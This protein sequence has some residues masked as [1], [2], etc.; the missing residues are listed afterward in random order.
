MLSIAIDHVT[1]R[2]RLQPGGKRHQ[3]RLARV[4][5]DALHRV[6]E[7]ELERAGVAA[8][9]HLCIREL[10]A[11]AS[12]RLR[13]P[14]E[15]LADRLGA[16]IAAAIA[17]AAHGHDGAEDGA[18][19]LYD[20]R[21]QALADLAAC[22]LTGRFE[23]SWAWTQLGLWHVDF[24]LPPSVAA[25]Q[26]ARELTR[27]PALA[28]AVI[29]HLAAT[30][31]AAFAAMI[32]H[33]TPERWSELARA[34]INASG[35]AADLMAPGAPRKLADATLLTIARLVA[36]QSAIGRELAASRRS[37]PAATRRTIAA[38]AILEIEPGILQRGADH[39]RA[40]LAAVEVAL[41]ETEDLQAAHAADRLVGPR[42][43]DTPAVERRP[44]GLW[45]P[46]SEPTPRVASAIASPSLAR[47]SAG[48]LL[49]LINLAARIGLP[50]ALLRDERVSGRGLRWAMHQL[51]MS[52]ASV[53]ATDPAA[54]AFAGLAPHAR[55]PSSLQPP[56]TEAEQDAMSEGRDA[57]VQAL[58]V[59]LGRPSDSDTTMLAFVCQ[60][61]A[62]I[63][64]DPGWI[65]VHLSLDDVSVEIRSAGLDLDPG[66]VA[67]LGVVVRF[68]YA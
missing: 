64:A 54:M 9:G 53:E 35:R 36:E 3:A 51:A 41:A 57:L 22:A 34:A 27:E 39:A 16:A 33:V 46:P 1:T 26:V 60:R 47:T 48:G 45:T 29:A 52:L 40:L 68:V 28:P 63:T 43:G 7:T 10:A 13:E 5:D 19:V 20:S 24:A 17:I 55:P 30:C 8:T 56:A 66:W 18:V 14:D 11:T 31:P 37:L 25:D 62:H 12:L 58:R 21:A 67:W 42:H 15:A 44:D 50:D 59:A 23:R 61:R 2:Y 49:Y 6:L 4:V 65:D 38:L 32:A